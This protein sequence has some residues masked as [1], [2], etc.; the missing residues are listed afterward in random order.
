M[1]MRQVLSLGNGT[2][3]LF[4]SPCYV[5]SIIQEKYKLF[6]RAVK[7]WLANPRKQEVKR[8]IGEALSATQYIDDLDLRGEETEERGYFEGE[9]EDY[10]WDS[11][12]HAFID[13]SNQPDAATSESDRSSSDPEDVVAPEAPCDA[14]DTDS[15]DTSRQLTP[16]SQKM[17]R[18]STRSR[19]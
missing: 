10:E 13:D 4:K 18:P 9:N 6:F 17:G 19:D 2:T 3:A 8:D 11:D 12:D 5:S 14:D 15:V 7:K 1:V 16:I